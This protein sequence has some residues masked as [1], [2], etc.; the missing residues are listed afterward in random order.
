MPKITSKQPPGTKISIKRSDNISSPETI[1]VKR[2]QPPVRAMDLAE[3][4]RAMEVKPGVSLYDPIDPKSN[5]I[6]DEFT[7]VGQLTKSQYNSMNDPYYVGPVAGRASP[8][9]MT[10]NE[11][12]EEISSY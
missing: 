3:P 12:A 11:L 9:Q 7:K 4:S 2:F 10:A 6:G 8:D 1:P 5:K